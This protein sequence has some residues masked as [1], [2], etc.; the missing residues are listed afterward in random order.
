MPGRQLY[1]EVSSASN[2]TDHQSRRLSARDCSGRHLHTV[3]GTACAA[4][5]TLLAVRETGQRRDG[6]VTV[7]P[8]LRP[9]M[10]GL[11]VIRP[12]AGRPQWI[13]GHQV[14]LEAAA[15]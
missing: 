1:G 9:L 15:E 3:N 4:P 7:P 13:R 11:E 6:T 8:V 12:R 10:A 2:C 5:R 14:R